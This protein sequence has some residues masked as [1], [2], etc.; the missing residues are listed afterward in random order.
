[1]ITTVLP[2]ANAGP[3]ALPMCGGVGESG[4]RDAAALEND[5]FDDLLLEVI[6]F[7]QA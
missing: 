7:G 3:N 5:E 1:L 2:H 6:V 4:A